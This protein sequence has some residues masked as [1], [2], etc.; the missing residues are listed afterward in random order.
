MTKTEAR[1]AGRPPRP[2]RGW[3]GWV[4]FASIML[5]I[6]GAINMVQGFAALFHDDVL[7][8]AQQGLLLGD[9]TAWG[10]ILLIWGGAQVLAGL[11]LNTGH[12]WARV[13]ALMVV[14]VSIVIQTVLVSPPSDVVAGDHRAR[15]DRHLRA[16]RAL[17]GGPRGPLTSAVA[18][19][20]A[21]L[22]RLLG[23][24][25]GAARLDAGPVELAGE[26][27]AARSC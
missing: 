4:V 15:R 5:A 19:R 21:Q 14:A 1:F 20:V 27:R 8:R 3:T 22:A 9:L 10:S 16:D 6:V 13:L 25:L 23:R 7:R 26:L 12:G 24:K 18:E 11:G 2:E 17:G